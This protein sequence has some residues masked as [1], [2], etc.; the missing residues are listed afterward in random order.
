A[1]N[2]T[3][4]FDGR[5]V[6]T[7]ASVPV[8]LSL[9]RG[10]DRLVIAQAPGGR[11]WTA[12]VSNRGGSFYGTSLDGDHLTISARSTAAAFVHLV[13]QFVAMDS[14]V[15]AAVA[16]GIWRT[17]AI[18]NI[19]AW[20]GTHSSTG[21][22]SM[23]TD[24]IALIDAGVDAAGPAIAGELMQAGNAGASTG[25]AGEALTAPT[26]LQRFGTWGEGEIAGLWAGNVTVD[27]NTVQNGTRAE[28]TYKLGGPNEYL[29]DALQLDLTSLDYVAA[30][31]KIDKHAFNPTAAGEPIPLDLGKDRAWPLDSATEVVGMFMPRPV[32]EL[33]NPLGLAINALAEVGIPAVGPIAQMPTVALDHYGAYSVRF[34]SGAVTSER[35]EFI[36]QHP[37]RPE[38][39]ARWQV[40]LYVNMLKATLKVASLVVK[41]PDNQA[42][43]SDLI[44]GLWPICISP[45]YAIT[46]LDK[47]G[48]FNAF[49][50]A[51]TRKALEICA[52]KLGKDALNA[53]L[54]ELG[55]V[56]LGNPSKI[57][58]GLATV[59]ITTQLVSLPALH[60]IV[61]T[62]GNWSECES[63][64]DCTA[65]AQ[66]EPDAQCHF[67]VSTMC[68]DGTK[69]GTE[70]DVDC[71][72]ACSQCSDGK[73]CIGNSDCQSG[74]CSSGSCTNMTN[75]ND[76]TKNGTETDVDCG[77][78]CSQCSA[79]KSCIGNS[80]CQSGACSS[81]SCTNTTNS[82]MRIAAGSSHTCALRPDGTA[83]CWGNNYG[84]QL[85]DG[86]FAVKNTPVMVSGLS[87]AIAITA[88]GGYTCALLADGTVQCWGYNVSGQLGDGTTTSKS[89]PVVVTGLSAAIAVTAG[90]GH[91]CALLAD[92]TAR[93]WGRNTYGE[94]G[95]GTTT[96]KHTAVTV[97]GLANTIALSVGGQ[98]T[99]GLLADRTVRCWG[100]NFWG[101]LGD[102]TMVDNH[103]PVPVSGIS[104]AIAVS[105]GEYHTCALLSDGTVRCWGENSSG[106]LGDG[107]TVVKS[108]PVPVSGL[109]NAVALTA[110]Y[111]HTCA[112]LAGG[113]ASCWG[114]NNYGELAQLPQLAKPVVRIVL[115]ER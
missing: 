85:G 2:A 87:A 22:T 13:P 44:T 5:E 72:G 78:S 8:T 89:A 64:M 68:N 31:D 67:K 38:L 39:T 50:T 98:H 110:G 109:S 90:G 111:F 47:P 23:D 103:T 86:T 11:V 3:I 113:T 42:F 61:L 112:L 29:P 28:L 25:S 49:A 34:F 95:D 41:L 65:D 70:T 4:W 104:N 27:W 20:L 14:T 40:A 93:C 33:A 80:D 84:G 75:C 69:N 83:K 9:E 62:A 58:S 105:A 91:T 51:F 106:Q 6:G 7:G 43:F 53:L 12:L 35:L 37:E 45:E 59:G 30:F 15:N 55:D 52:E 94:L 82:G 56:V 79:G 66:C 92:G 19:A 63:D 99:C 76:G 81:G 57:V 17:P 26:M 108:L 114:N 97:S 60:S 18:D 1:E 88:G 73:S 102:G 115:T 107:T 54:A 101:Q 21:A 74:A 71:G 48:R 46:E 36:R 32:Y 96:D 100:R 16:D 77:G 10:A 24:F